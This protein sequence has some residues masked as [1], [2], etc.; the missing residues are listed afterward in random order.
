M[1][2]F[3]FALSCDNY[4]IIKLYYIGKEFLSEKQVYYI[5]HFPLMG[6]VADFNM[7][8]LVIN[9]ICTFI[10][11]TNNVKLCTNKRSNLACSLLD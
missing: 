5:F 10:I 8:Y 6:H 4:Y 11:D 7:F 2:V 1:C 9:L 3:V